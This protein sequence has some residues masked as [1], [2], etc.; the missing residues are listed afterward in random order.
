MI[1]HHVGKGI[2]EAQ[3]RRWV[4]LMDACADA[5]GLPDNPEFCSAFVGSIECGARLAGLNGAPDVEVEPDAPTPPW[6]WGETGGP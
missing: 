6:G 4:Q 5:A 1:E 3:R 2:S